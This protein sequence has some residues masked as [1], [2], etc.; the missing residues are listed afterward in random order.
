MELSSIHKSIHKNALFCGR[1][2]GY[3][4]IS[5]NSSTKKLKSVDGFVD[6]L[7]HHSRS[8]KPSFYSLELLSVILA[9]RIAAFDLIVFLPGS[10]KSVCVIFTLF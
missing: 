2:C 4:S 10:V 8:S 6:G 9:D 7:N 1:F 5:T 3:R